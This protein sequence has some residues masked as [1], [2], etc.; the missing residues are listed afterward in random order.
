MNEV[1]IVFVGVCG[2][3]KTLNRIHTQLLCQI[4]R[5]SLNIFLRVAKSSIRSFHFNVPRKNGTT[6]YACS[7]NVISCNKIMRCIHITRH[8]KSGVCRV[9][10]VL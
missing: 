6:S 10:S 5:S 3:D 4:S 9:A 8:K 7:D 1:I 2:S